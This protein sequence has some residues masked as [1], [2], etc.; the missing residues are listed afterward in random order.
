MEAKFGQSGGS[1]SQIAGSPI[2]EIVVGGET[3]KGV[4]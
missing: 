1:S 2:R 4:K 3:N